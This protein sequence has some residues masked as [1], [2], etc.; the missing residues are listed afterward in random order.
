MCFAANIVKPNWIAWE[1]YNYHDVI[2][3]F[4]LFLQYFHMRLKYFVGFTLSLDLFMH[5]SS[6]R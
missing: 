1:A 3:S 6:A 4:T 2:Q 5:V